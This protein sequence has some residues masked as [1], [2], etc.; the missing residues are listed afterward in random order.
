[1]ASP[2]DAP[3]PDTPRTT[4]TDTVSGGT[5]VGL[6]CHRRALGCRDRAS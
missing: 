5:T 2:F 3:S 1:M 6:H 4:N